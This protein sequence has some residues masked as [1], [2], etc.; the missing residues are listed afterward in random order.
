MEQLISIFQKRK[1]KT[2]LLFSPTETEDLSNLDYECDNCGSNF[3][4]G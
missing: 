1:M 2:A 3:V 4:K